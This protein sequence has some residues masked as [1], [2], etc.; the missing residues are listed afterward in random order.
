MGAVIGATIMVKNSSNGT[1]T[2]IDG[3]Y[4]IEVP[5][6]ATLLFSFVGYST[7]EKEVG[8]NTV[9]NVEL[10]DDIQAIDEVV[11]TAIGIKQQKKKIGY[12]TQQINSEVL[13]ATPS[14]N[15]GSALSGQVA[16][17]LVANPTGIFQAPSFKLRGNAPLVVLDGVP[18]ETDF[19]DISSEN[20]ESVN[21]LKVR[22]PQLYTVHAGKTEQ[23]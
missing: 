13:N 17:L 14:L 15:V 18:V 11:V 8:N 22:Q 16:G 21:V 19:F 7:V 20:I 9:I 10:S 3:R 12:T 4:S 5:K 1:V 6:N 2:D 23:F